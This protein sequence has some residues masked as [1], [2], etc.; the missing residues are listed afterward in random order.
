[1]IPLLIFYVH[2]VG[3]T[4]AFTS[5][6]QKEGLSAGFL[7]VGFFVLIFSVGWSISSFMLKYLIDAPGFG[8]WLNRDT[9][10]LVILT[11]CEGFF[12]FFYFKESDEQTAHGKI[13]SM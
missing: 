11:V 9:L 2:I 5:E 12:Y 6:Y 7:S 3:I 8:L 4:A 13:T 10:A 1:M